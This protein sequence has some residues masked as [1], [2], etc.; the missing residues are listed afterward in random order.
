MSGAKR[1]G[2][3]SRMWEA[4][5]PDRQCDRQGCLNV[6]AYPAPRSRENLK[7]YVW[8]CLDHVREYNAKWNFHGGMTYEEIEASIRR[9]TVWDRPTWPFSGRKGAGPGDFYDPLHL[10]GQ[11][12]EHVSERRRPLT[13][14][15]KALAL[16]ELEPSASLA[17]VKARYKALVKRWHPDANGGDK[18]AEERLKLINQAYA[19]LKAAL[20]G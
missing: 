8:L 17:E 11:G 1:S 5:A 9:D 3:R 18:H 14:A 19:S 10:F 7:A 12:K 2:R 13:E 16:F 20:A 15:E 6:G 4:P